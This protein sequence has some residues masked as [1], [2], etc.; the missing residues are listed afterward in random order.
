MDDD[1]KDKVKVKEKYKDFC[2]LDRSFWMS[3]PHYGTRKKQVSNFKKV[4]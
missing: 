2:A 1:V 4:Y 3:N